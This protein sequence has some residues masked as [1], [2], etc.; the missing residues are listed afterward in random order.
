MINA[1]AEYINVLL[2]FFYN[3]VGDYG[4][5]I[6]ILTVLVNVITFPLTRKQLQA[7]KK[8]QAIQ[9][10]LKRLQEKYKGDKEKYNQATMEFMKD[11]KV[12]P[13]GGCLPLLIQFPILIAVFTLLK[14][15]DMIRGTV[16]D[17]NPYFLFFNLDLTMPDPLYILPILAATATFF[18]QKF[19]MT[20]PN[21][22]MFLYVFPV[23]IMVISVSFPAG[24]VLYWFTNSLFSIGNHFMIKTGDEVKKADT[25]TEGVLKNDRSKDYT[26]G[27][28]EQQ[29]GNPVPE[30]SDRGT[31]AHK[32]SVSREAPKVK[33]K[34]VKKKKKKKGAGKQK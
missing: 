19:V 9:P 20:D 3:L 8:M 30:K 29:T 25:D 23:M 22:K 27:K 18:Q 31:N 1:L 2:T 4:L 11:N 33:K 34:I 10:E 28:V 21:Q 7:S 6:I 14:N 17:F 32:K 24:L 16:T 5:A 15:P 12:N 26:S 13:L